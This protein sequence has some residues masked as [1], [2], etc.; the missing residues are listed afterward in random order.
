MSTRGEGGVKK[1]QKSV[2]VVCER[3]LIEKNLLI[4]Q[5]NLYCRP[6]VRVGGMVWNQPTNFEQWMASI[7]PEICRSGL[8]VEFR[9]AFIIKVKDERVRFKPATCSLKVI[10]GV[11][12]LFQNSFYATSFK[13]RNVLN[14][15][16]GVSC[17]KREMWCSYESL[18]PVFSGR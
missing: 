4:K 18:R 17:K 13:R 14:F 8:R 5:K 7:R 12:V 16:T 11:P 10:T 1:V 9:S 15:C 6:S 2:N 3:P